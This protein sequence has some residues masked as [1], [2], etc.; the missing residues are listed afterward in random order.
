[1]M[2]DSRPNPGTRPMQEVLEFVTANP[3]SSRSDIARGLAHLG[4]SDRAHAVAM[5]ELRGAIQRDGIRPATY[6]PVGVLEPA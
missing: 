6:A 4:W 2:N 3:S 1:M 5:L